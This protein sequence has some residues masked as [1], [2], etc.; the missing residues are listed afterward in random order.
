M[1][2]DGA[3]GARTLIFPLLNK[4]KKSWR[5][6]MNFYIELNTPMQHMS[7]RKVLDLWLTRSFMQFIKFGTKTIR[8]SLCWLGC[9]FM[10]FFSYIQIFFYNNLFIFLH[11]RDLSLL[12][13]LDY[14]DGN[15]YSMGRIISFKR[16]DSWKIDVIER[17]ACMPKQKSKIIHLQFTWTSNLLL[18][19]GGTPLLAMHI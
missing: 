8:S 11:V 18:T 10:A 1:S 13:C 7:N 19:L 17:T 5:T 9:S 4:G 6:W 2:S 14:F 16:Y 15:V 3:H 12:R